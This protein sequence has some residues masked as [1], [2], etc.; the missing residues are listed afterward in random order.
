MPNPP[1]WLKQGTAIY[2]TER[3]LGEVLGIVGSQLIASFKS[4]HQPVSIN[5]V[6]AIET[7][8]LMPASDIV[9]KSSELNRLQQPSF[10]SSF[11]KIALGLAESIVYTETIPAANGELYPLPDNLPVA[12]ADALS[13]VD[14]QQIYSHQLE[15]LEALRQGKDICILT[16]TASGKTWCFNIPILES[17]LTSNATALYLYP[18]KAL[19][20]DQIDKLRSLV[21]LLPQNATVKVGVMT[22]DVSVSERKRLFVPEPPQILGVSPDLLHYQLYAV[23]AKDS[24]AGEEFEQTNL[25]IAYREVFPGAIYS[26]QNSDGEIIKY[27]S[28]ELNVE[29]R[30][31]I[32]TPIDPQS[33]TFTMA[34]TD[35]EVKLLEPLA[36]P[37]TIALSIP[38][39]EIKLTLGWGEVKSSVTGYRLCVRQYELTCTHTGCRYY[40]QPLSGKFCQACGSKLKRIE[41]VTVVDEVTFN[42]PYC[43]QYK[44]PVV[45]VE[46][47]SVGASFISR[48][49]QHLKAKLQRQ[50]KEIPPVYT[51]LWEAYP[52][53][54]ALHSM[55]HQIVFAVPLVILSSSLYLNYLVA[56]KEETVAY[57]YDAV[58]D[59][60]G[61]S[62]AVFHQ[63]DKFAQNAALLAKN[64]NCEA[65]CPKCLYMHGCPQD[66]ESLNKQIGLALLTSISE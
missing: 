47:N 52:A 33:T 60:N 38:N 5:W 55:G 19:A 66:N 1:A 3:G 11:E 2:S 37:K 40:H 10:N 31:A 25:D 65:G 30:R 24:S 28:T 49:V 53:R 41:L 29:E 48:E 59:G 45:R 26:A 9:K 16:P 22:G 18:L 42:Q 13:R 54:I 63:F 35:F 58:A 17:C 62:E 20:T 15:S 36:D 23:R 46:I 56:E 50:L 14:I 4:E 51:A 64:C 21:A 32:L 43:T 57:F 7:Q 34:E 6:S 12:L 27:K 61:C 8:E 44:T 39:A